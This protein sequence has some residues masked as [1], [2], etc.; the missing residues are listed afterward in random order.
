[1]FPLPLILWVYV[2]CRK[3]DGLKK[4]NFSLPD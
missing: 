2:S 1:V 4:Q 3:I